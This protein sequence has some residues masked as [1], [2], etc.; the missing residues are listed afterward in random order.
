MTSAITR[1]SSCPIG[2]QSDDRRALSPQQQTTVGGILS[3][4]NPTHV[5]PSRKSTLTRLNYHNMTI[6]P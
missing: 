2:A 1:R 5:A 6:V 4:G 3:R